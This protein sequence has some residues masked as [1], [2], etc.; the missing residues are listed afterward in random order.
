MNEEFSKQE[1]SWDKIYAH[2]SNG[3]PIWIR[4]AGIEPVA[5]G[6]DEYPCLVSYIG[7][8]SEGGMIK[9][10]VPPSE[11]GVKD[12]CMDDL[13]TLIKYP[14]PVVVSKVLRDDGILVYSRKNALKVLSNS[15]WNELEV[16]QIKEG[17]LLTRVSIK[18]TA[19]VDIGGGIVTVPSHEITWHKNIV[20][21][22]LQQK[23]PQFEK[24]KVMITKVDPE[25]KK[26]SGSIKATES[27]PWFTTYPQIYSPGSIHAGKIVNE[28]EMG[29]YVRL[30]SGVTCMCNKKP[31]YELNEP[32]SIG[33]QVAV[34]IRKIDSER[35]R[36]S[37]KPVKSGGLQSIEN[38]V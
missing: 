33:S 36:I 28:N 8:D 23:L 15:L 26:I 24:V 38:I 10:Y 11:L 3:T 31:F 6:D 17:V 34:R 37:G 29:V 12:A 7:T 30:E 4:F 14:I 21:Y 20:Y 13:L 18:D 25:G 5:S 22:E 27:N 16:G 35:Q 32:M 9:G 1:F 2:Q 19:C